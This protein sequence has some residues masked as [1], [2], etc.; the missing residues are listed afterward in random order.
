MSD[1]IL[2]DTTRELYVQGCSTN[3]ASET[4]DIR[5]RIKSG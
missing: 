5:T 2:P 3:H 4:I 1:F